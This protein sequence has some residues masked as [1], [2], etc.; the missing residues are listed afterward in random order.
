MVLRRGR[1]EY[2]CGI[3]AE[4]QWY[5]SLI[6]ARIHHT[7]PRVGK[8]IAFR[9]NAPG[10]VKSVKLVM[11]GAGVAQLGGGAEAIESLARRKKLPALTVILSE[12][13]RTPL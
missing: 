11:T 3:R 2:G 4:T 9:F 10:Q 6:Q 1:Q 8:H 7:R 12:Y 5:G 13:T